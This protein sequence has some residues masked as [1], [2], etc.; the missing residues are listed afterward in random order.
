[1]F[2]GK[3]YVAGMV[4]LLVFA[5]C[6]ITPT[7]IEG[8]LGTHTGDTDTDEGLGTLEIISIEPFIASNG[9]GQEVV[10]EAS[11]LDSDVEILVGGRTSLIT[12]TVGARIT[13]TV[14]PSSEEGWV[15]V[16]L[17]TGGRSASK[18]EGLYLWED[19]T[20]LVGAVGVL[21]RLQEIDPLDPAVQPTVASTIYFVQPTEFETAD[22]WA[23]QLGKCARDYTPDTSALTRLR[24]GMDTL[25]LSSGSRSFGVGVTATD[26]TVFESDLGSSDYISNARY[27]LEEMTGDMVWPTGDIGGFVQTPSG[28]MTVTEPL[29][30]SLAATVS[31]TV[32]L[33]WQDAGAG[34][35]VLIQLLRYDDSTLVD[36]VSCVVPD[37]GSFTVSSSNFSGWS[38]FSLMRVRVGESKGV[39][40]DSSAQSIQKRCVRYP[41]GARLG[42]TVLGLSAGL[43]HFGQCGA[44]RKVAVF[45]ELEQ[46]LHF[47]EVTSA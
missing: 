42:Q 2:L 31:K 39:Q 5:G 21:E 33:K 6:W 30:D 32:S 27:D 47:E 12:E 26:A 35:F 14:P 38:T 44:M 34:D 20:G 23:P 8:K 46:F 13:F 43:V 36:V 16:E 37:N 7:E 45:I 22:F 11:T 10:L 19:G 41:L 15:P 24:T 25:V 9:G 1:M 3:I 40:R 29:L 18:E 28:E 4:S 17:V